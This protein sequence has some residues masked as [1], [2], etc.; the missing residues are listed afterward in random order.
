MPLVKVSFSV[1]VASA[2]PIMI[3]VKRLF[4]L[5]FFLISA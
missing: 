5:F 3:V 4:L 1:T 2:L